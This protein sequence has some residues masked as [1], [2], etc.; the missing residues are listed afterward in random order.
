[1]KI[2]VLN[3]LKAKVVLKFFTQTCVAMMNLKKNYQTTLIMFHYP[4]SGISILKL[5]LGNNDWENKYNLI[6]EF[7]VTFWLNDHGIKFGFLFLE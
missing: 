7:L 3:Q 6:Q 2:K 5:V 1:M 4:L